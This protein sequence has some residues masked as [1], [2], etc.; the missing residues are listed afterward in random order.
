METLDLAQLSH[1]IG[2]NGPEAVFP[3]PPP[4]P[5]GRHLKKSKKKFKKHPLASL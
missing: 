3:I 2:G 5:P 4:E 1:V